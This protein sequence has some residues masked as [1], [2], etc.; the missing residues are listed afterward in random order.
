M[1]QAFRQEQEEAVVDRLNGS[2]RSMTKPRM[3]EFAE[4][5]HFPYKR[6]IFAPL[7]GGALRRTSGGGGG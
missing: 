1:A 4:A 7:P 3:I 2:D 5:R 6:T